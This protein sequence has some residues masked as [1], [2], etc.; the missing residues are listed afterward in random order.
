M[1]AQNAGWSTSGDAA[2]LAEAAASVGEFAFAPGSEDAALI[3]NVPPRFYTAQV[4]GLT[5][6]RASPRWKFTSCSNR[7]NSGKRRELR[8]QSSE[9]RQTCRYIADGLAV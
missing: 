7:R 2:A 1:V 3:V 9:A 8:A 4:T 5:A 6:P